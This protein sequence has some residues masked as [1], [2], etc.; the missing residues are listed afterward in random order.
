M[1]RKSISKVWLPPCQRKVEALEETVVQQEK[2]SRASASEQQREID[3]LKATRNELAIQVASRRK[4]L[5]NPSRNVSQKRNHGLCRNF[6]RTQRTRVSRRGSRSRHA[7]AQLNL[8]VAD[9][10]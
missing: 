3:S 8:A 5:R 10:A 7:A 2:D 1:T 4:I 6:G 9:R